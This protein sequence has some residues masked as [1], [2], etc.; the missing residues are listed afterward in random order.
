MEKVGIWIDR[1]NA[2]IF[3]FSEEKERI[4]VINSNIQFF[5]HTGFSSSK[6]K[7]GGPQDV[8]PA[9]N[10]EEKEKNQLNQYFDDIIKLIKKVDAIAVY[11]PGSTPRLFAN[12][13][14]NKDKTLWTKLKVVEK[15]DKMTDNQFKSLVHNFYE[16]LS[17]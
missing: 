12:R 7:W 16:S 3:F 13:L 5:K 8:L 10:I 6:F 1:K 14:E 11:G 17:I 15:A 9:K 2:K 4:E